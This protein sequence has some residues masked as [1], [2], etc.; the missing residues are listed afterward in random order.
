MSVL[1]G[2][3]ALTA[4]LLRVDPAEVGPD[5]APLALGF[6]SLLAIGLAH[7]AESELGVRVSVAD[8]LAGN[9]LRHL[10]SAGADLPAAPPGPRAVER[11]ERPPLSAG[12]RRMWLLDQLNPGAYV[13]AAVITLPDTTDVAERLSRVVA[14]HEVLRTV[15]PVDG[16]EPHQ[17]VLPPRPVVPITLPDRTAAVAALTAEPFDLA[18]GP[19][20]RAA[21]VPGAGVVGGTDLVLVA[22][23]I[24]CDG[25]SLGVLLGELVADE[26]PPLSLHYADYALW[27]RELLDGGER[28][29]QLA[30]WRTVFADLPAPLE[31]P[32]DRPRGGTPVGAVH[33]HVLPAD[34]RDALAGVARAHG[35][36]EFTVLHAAYAAFLSRLTGQRDVV[37]AIPV[38][39]RPDPALDPL[40]GFFVNT[41]ALRT[42]LSDDPAFDVL[43][44][45]CRDVVR[46]AQDHQDLP[47]DELVEAL[48]PD[49]APGEAPL[50]QTLLSLRRRPSLGSASAVELPVGGAKFDLSL[51]VEDTGAEWWLRWEYRADRFDAATVAGYAG[52]FTVLVDAAVD[53]PRRPIG[54]L[55]L[56]TPAEATA[57]VD[58]GEGPVVEDVPDA[59]VRFADAERRFADRVALRGNGTTLTYAELGTRARALAAELVARG[60]GP[61]TLI[62]L[63]AGRGTDTVV[64]LWAVLLAG[65]AYLPLDPAHPPRRLAAVVEATRPLLVLAEPGLPELP[66]PTRPLRP[67]SVESFVDRG[68]APGNLAYVLH[69]SGSTGVPKGV[70]VTRA[71]LANLLRAMDSVL[72]GGEPQTWLALTS[73]AF[74]ISVVELV[75]TLTTGATVVL[76]D[77]RPVV[78]QL[79]GVTHL[80]T[81]PSFATR[82]LTTA[83]G[84]LTGLHTL[85]LGGEVIS[86]ALRA[87]LRDLPN[88]R[89][90]NGYGPTEATVYATTAP[91]DP[92]ADRSPIGLPVSGTTARPLDRGLDPT[93]TAG[94]LHLGGAGVARGYLGDPRLTAARFL[95]D[96]HGE[97]GARMYR[98]GDLAHVDSD[99]TL[100]YHGREDQQAKVNGYRVELGEITA[101]LVA[102]PGVR[103]AHTALTPGPTITAYLV[104]EVDPDEVRA[105]L[106]GLLPVWLHPTH[107]VPIAELPLTVNGKLD[108]KRLPLPER[109]ERVHAAPRG[110]A[111]EAVAGVWTRL[112]GVEN[113]SRTDDFFTHGG[114][115]LLAAQLTAALRGELGRDLPVRA[116]FEHPTIAALTAYALSCPPVDH[117]VVVADR[118]ARL[119]LSAAQW[120]IWVQSQ[121]TGTD[122]YVIAGAVRVVGDPPTTLLRA[123]LDAL[124][125]RH[126][127]LRTTFPTDADGPRQLVHPPAPVPLPVLTPEEREGFLTRGFDLAEGPLLRAA[128]VPADGGAELLIAV[129]HIVCDGWSLAVLF[130]ELTGG[131][132]PELTVQYP[133]HALHEA[134]R[135]H[136]ADLAHW[137]RVLTDLP[138]P[139]RLP[140]D[141]PR[142]A[143]W[144][145]RGGE[146]RQVLDPWLATRLREVAAA[147]GVTVFM[148]LTAAFSVLVGRLSG[149]TDVVV[150]T[151]V[152]HRPDPAL[153]PLVGLFLNTV[154]LRVDLGDNP[155]GAELLGRVRE[156]VLAAHEHQRAPFEDVVRE[157]GVLSTADTHPV[158]QVLLSVR[159]DL[160][161]VVE[162]DGVAYH[163]VALSTGTAKFDLSVEAVGLEREAPELRWEYRAQLF[164]ATTAARFAGHLRVLLTALTDAPTAPV[165]T[166]PLLT[167]AQHAAAVAVPEPTTAPIATVRL[168]DAVGRFADRTALV[169]GDRLLTYQEFHDRAHAVAAKLREL[170]AGPERLVGLHSVRGINTVIGLWATLLTGAAYLPLDPTHPPARLRAIVADADPVAV[171]TESGAGPVPTD[172][173]PVLDL[174]ADRPAVGADW[175]RPHPASLAYVLYTSGSTGAPKGVAITHANL[176][177]LLHAMDELLGADEPQTWPA[178]T[179]PAFDISVVE[180]IWTLTTGA[181]VVLPDT[182]AADDL[183]GITHLQTTPSNAVR[184]LT[185]GTAALRGL[186]GL[187]LGGEPIS[188]ALR[189][190]LA[191]LTGTRHL[192]GYGP[193]E[194]TVYAT[195]APIDPAARDTP[196]GSPVAGTGAVVLEPAGLPAP[197]GVVGD[198]H[199]TG[200]GV[201]RGYLGNP[202]LTAARFVP[203]PHGPLGA[204]AY[205]TGDLVRRDPDGVLRF[206]GRV[207]DQV[208]VKGY[209]VE[210]GEVTAVLVR[211]PAVRSAHTGLGADG[212]IVSYVVWADEPAP[213]ALAAH[214]AELLPAW[215]RPADLVPLAEL[216]LTVNGK[217]DTRRL[218]VPEPRDRR[219]RAPESGAEERVAALFAELL[220]VPVDSA[221][222]DFFGM[223]G[224]SLLATRLA[225]RLGL[226]LRAVFDH[227]TVAGL[228]AVLPEAGTAVEPTRR[229]RPHRLP[230]SAA[231][232]RLWFLEQFAPGGYAVPVS[233][234]I[235][236]APD[237]DALAAALAALVA[238]HEAL[239]TT[240]P[241]DAGGPVQHIS[242]PAP[243]PLPE[244][245]AAERDAFTAA[246]FDLAE[247][248]L[249]RAAVIA[250]PDEDEL[251]LVLHHAVCDNWSL[252]LLL[253]E[254]VDL[255]GGT[256]PVAPA[257]QCADHALW[258]A[259]LLAGPERERQ[260]AHWLDRLADPPA[261]LPL[262]TDRPRPRDPAV[263]GARLTRALP[264]DTAACLREL[265]ASRGVTLFSALYAAYTATLA[266]VGGQAD[267]VVGTPVAN[268]TRPELA[269]AVGFLA[270]T[271]ALRT[272]AEADTPF[273][274]LLDR[275]HQRVRDALDHQDLPFEDLVEQLRLPRDHTRNPLFQ[276]MLTL[277]HERGPRTSANGHTV[278]A[279]GRDTGAA[280]VDLT[281]AVRDTGT[282]LELSWEYPT[283]LFDE[284]TVAG[285]AD[286]FTTL[287]AAAVAD[288]GTPVGALPLLPPRQRA[289]ALAAGTA[290]A[291]DGC[292]VPVLDRFAEQVSAVPDA[293]ALRDDSTAMTYRELDSRSRDLAAYLRTLG[294]GPDTLVGLYA[295]RSVPLVVGMVAVLRAGGAYLP[296][297]PAY[298]PSRVRAIL[299]HARPPVVLH[300]SP[301]STT[302]AVRL[303]PL[304]VDLPPAPPPA[305]LAAPDDLAYAIY[306][307]GSTGE[308]KGVAVTRANLATSTAARLAVYG[309]PVSGFVLVSS[310]AFDTSVASIF[311]SLATGAELYLP[312]A[313]TEL[314]LD[315]LAALLRR[316][317]ATHLVCLPSLY[318]LLLD[319]FRDEPSALRVV[320]VAGEPVDPDLVAR[321]HEVQPE[322]QLHNEYGPT[323]NTVWSTVARLSPGAA[324][325]IG[326]PVPGSGAH[327]LDPRG[328]P[329]PNGVVG[330]LRLTGPCLAR[331]YLRDPRLTADRFRPDPHGPPGARAYRTGDLAHRDPTGA[332]HFRGRSD[333][334]VKIRGYRVEPGEVAAAL[335]AH[336]GVEAAHCVAR[337]GP[338]LV[339]YFV[340]T[341]AVR[342]LS[343]HLAEHLPPWLRPAHL[344]PLPDLPR[345]PN[346]KVDARALP[347][348]TR[349]T[350]PTA[351]PTTR[352]EEEVAG[353]L[354][355]LLGH[356]DI[357]G[358]GVDDSFFD[359]GAHS[360]LLVR[361]CDL[362]R[363]MRAD[364]R[365]VDLF[366]YPTV[367]SLASF[368]SGTA[369][370]DQGSAVDAA[371]AGAAVGRSRLS[372]RRARLTTDTVLEG[373]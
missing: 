202:R 238:R 130:D 257:T 149:T 78:D 191:D 139:L 162:A 210:L 214:L 209:R 274:E 343:A 64:A 195:T 226:P 138:D 319:R 255:L 145:G 32:A 314:D 168:R 315:R 20:L 13:L 368:L 305:D 115:S 10:A 95:P 369:D 71:N 212:A 288:P 258:Q 159:P 282:G 306:T 331:G 289:A 373:P 317:S 272:P 352:V 142:P 178:L 166:L 351:A 261:G 334:Q 3:V 215:A 87:L 329:C 6:D 47:F 208:K 207:D 189:D 37:V 183:S 344:V 330:E 325:P 237:R 23:H 176:A 320:A 70:A 85:L 60:A 140:A 99:G 14:R 254:L 28:K 364:L 102:H 180:L 67:T 326:F 228:A 193:T 177:N 151:P 206:T 361:A 155:T 69:T 55:P 50:A 77:E 356:K 301:L 143:E 158:F 63:Y 280:K 256:V 2:L 68:V 271:L 34:L 131:A 279:E 42:D 248:P 278:T 79:D 234:R 293:V 88:T 11:P 114:Q 231:Q 264:A 230:L 335:L 225:T 341:A 220:A 58:L 285:F 303:V 31:L 188:Q 53:R 119:P 112:L 266:R 1:E 48:A 175:P 132:V 157:V 146:H 249:L 171:L 336:H 300:D 167:P 30:H 312:R 240:F 75:W 40:I 59:G 275:C 118:P 136:S 197:D 216:P 302:D 38:A 91:I 298:P 144:D 8:V 354:R 109:V 86:P 128:L 156:T 21:L 307:S 134:G 76:P 259:D 308:P 318:R 340:G 219:G 221:E 196:I 41:V 194:A 372:R 251:V 81:T 90:V 232:R 152:S 141:R 125:A 101:A 54:E 74:D 241:S 45:R 84:A 92:T 108:A 172:G 223:G 324:A 244:I 97:P 117:R 174:G 57:L 52:W 154:A 170:G 313:G 94:E 80:Q 292:D 363:P 310:P 185:G 284:H 24:V 22:H 89:H 29:R 204:R 367:R 113:P 105:H 16:G 133:D 164:D 181:T 299:D 96:P 33:E 277:R 129:H 217:L 338:E 213:A 135:D 304:D 350:A 348:P 355:E 9:T 179:S 39:N 18:T 353:V 366:R 122:A 51:E 26:A 184:L 322:V 200:A 198:L 211:H 287:V 358:I 243:V 7:E 150:G 296:L 245:T 242:P 276:A 347:A 316:P 66:A 339:A 192:N 116:V 103:D 43:L 346:G 291:A 4:R 295:H 163:P 27:H 370:P 229:E 265:A 239:R 124:V 110:P 294:V 104:G 127:A 137:A 106:A 187:L 333:T 126:E 252:E 73:T 263:I 5:S 246:P 345:T 342:E 227:S 297:D 281:L 190:L 111:E 205:R 160:P 65:A 283:A 44:G 360:L 19:L 17:R 260:L 290:P 362:L 224:H 270:N 250:H 349:D 120:R 371:P 107:L 328:E 332:L 253:D 121:L 46:D 268:R 165:G 236:P 173:V 93:P 233:A 309:G 12:Q 15:F 153:E 61:E 337:P 147:H 83:P 323:E 201:G 182:T 365:V 286:A 98:T 267:V 62:G 357:G 56:L 49:R 247:G 269:S 262:P 36:T 123:R 161:E 222:A 218:P 72:G 169:Q 82:L 203:D 321:H 100:H 148:L 199:L 311:W 35:V 186:R 25:W 327:V 235:R 359:L 273:G